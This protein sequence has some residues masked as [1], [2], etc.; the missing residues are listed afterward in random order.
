MGMGDRSSMAVAQAQPHDQRVPR[1]YSS[2]GH[3]A[4]AGLGDDLQQ[5]RASALEVDARQAL[6]AHVARLQALVQVGFRARRGRR[7][8]TC[9]AG[10]P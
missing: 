5:R 3:A 1:A 10:D 7:S 9:S 4:C 2:G 8:H 6:A